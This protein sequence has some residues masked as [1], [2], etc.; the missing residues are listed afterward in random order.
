M[1]ISTVLVLILGV[2]FFFVVPFVIWC[3]KSEKLQKIL[4]I[5]YFCCYLCVLFVG[6]FGSLSIGERYITINFDFTRDWRAKPINIS[7]SGIGKF[8]LIINLVM[9][10]PAGMFILFLARRKKWWIKLI[11]LA[12]IGLAIGATIET[13]QFILPVPRSVQLSDALL[14]MTS[15]FIGGLIG[16]AYLWIIGRI[17]RKKVID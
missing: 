14:N 6:V 13:L 1:T 5:I 8:D 15:V 17:F 7:L 3:F 16:W 4:M 10:Y 11:M 9:L 12:T 2:I